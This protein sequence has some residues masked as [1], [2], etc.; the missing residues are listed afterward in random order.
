MKQLVEE[1]ASKIQAIEHEKS[2]LSE[3]MKE[4][5][6]EYEDKL[7]TKTFKAA[8]RIAKIKSVFRGSDAELENIIDMLD[9]P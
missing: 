8:L 9:T 7:D 3:Q 6:A 4:L 5:F 2:I 1:L